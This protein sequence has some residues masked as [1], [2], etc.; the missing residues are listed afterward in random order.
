MTEDFFSIH[1]K[2]NDVSYEGRVSPEHRDAEGEPAS[3]HIVLNNVFFGYLTKNGKHWQVNEQRPEA[4]V[5][6]VG[7]CI[8]NEQN[9]KEA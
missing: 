1:F 9:L 3:Y 8:E 7:A 2:Y 5:E 4:L 6:L